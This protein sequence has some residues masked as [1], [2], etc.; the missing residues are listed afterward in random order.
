MTFSA[1]F[2]ALTGLLAALA[3]VWLWASRGGPAAP[4]LVLIGGAAAAVAWAI[5]PWGRLSPLAG[6]AAALAAGAAFWL[7]ALE[8]AL[9][10]T[11]LLARGFLVLLTLAALHTALLFGALVAAA[12]ASATERRDARTGQRLRGLLVAAAIALAT[13]T[14]LESGAR[15]LSPLRTYELIPD[16]PAAGPCLVRTADGRL[17]GVRGC[18]GRYI[19]REFDGVRVE[20]NALG[21]RDGLDETAPP[22]PGERS[23]L[24]LGDSFAYGM[25]VELEHSFQQRLGETLRQRGVAARV[26]GAAMPGAG[27]VHQRRV[28][29]ELGRRVSPDLVVASLFEDNDLQENRGARRRDGAAAPGAGAMAAPPGPP[30]PWR[31]LASTAGWPFWRTTSSLLQLRRVDGRPTAVLEAA[32][33]LEPPPEIEPM[34]AAVLAELAAIEAVTRDLGAELAV[35]LIPAIVQAEPER[36]AAFE[37]RHPHDTYSRTAFHEALLDD[38]GERGFR[39]VDPLPR[40]ETEAAAGRPCYHR[41]GHWNAHGHA[42]VAELL[43]EKLAPLLPAAG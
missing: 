42:V 38:L 43:A 35:L 34:R 4:R 24:V 17:T 29:E 13:L 19:H 22:G 28:L 6:L 26:Y 37:A 27:T 31:F 5:R 23:V 32:L 9:I 8:V 36:F 2:L 3:Q 15:A 30:T 18:R 40:L 20:I 7:G 21:L 1:R 16:E 12:A 11:V 39:V 41:E 14:L 33:R 25:G 10:S